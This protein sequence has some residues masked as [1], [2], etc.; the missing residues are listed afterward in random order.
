MTKKYNVNS[1][2]DNMNKFAKNASTVISTLNGL[3][4]MITSDEDVI[5]IDVIDGNDIQLPSY[6]NVLKRLKV[7][8][9][10]V[11]AFTSGKGS[12]KAVDGTNRQVKVETLPTTPSKIS[13]ISTPSSFKTNANWFF[14]SLMFPKILV[15]IDLLIQN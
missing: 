8:E 10:T 12:V 13:N 15:S 1:F 9:D 4:D 3:S 2:A 5:K 7:V 6:Q 14:E 11:N